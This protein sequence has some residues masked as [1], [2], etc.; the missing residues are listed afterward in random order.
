VLIGNVPNKTRI[1]N[2]RHNT[3]RNGL[4]LGRL[5]TCRAAP[6]EDKRI[7]AICANGEDDHSSVS[8]RYAD[9]RGSNEETDNG[10]AL[11]NGDV[12]CALVELTRGPGDCDCDSARDQVGWAC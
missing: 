8:T 2:R 4:L 12:P 10:Y 9:G 11:G 1:H 3:N 7:N 6:S 5:S